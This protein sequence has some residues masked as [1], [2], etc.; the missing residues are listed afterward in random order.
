MRI[1]DLNDMIPGEG[2]PAP[3]DPGLHGLGTGNETAEALKR[4]GGAATSASLDAYQRMVEASRR[5]AML[6]AD[7]KLAEFDAN[8]EAPG[9][10]KDTHQLEKAGGVMAIATKEHEALTAQIA[11]QYDDPF[12]QQRIAEAGQQRRGALQR[13][14]AE[15]ELTQGKTA[16][17]QRTEANNKWAAL[18]ARNATNIQ[19]P[20]VGPDALRAYGRI[21]DNTMSLYELGTKGGVGY[22]RANE[23]A[24]EATTDAVIATYLQ[25]AHDPRANKPAL[26]SQMEELAKRQVVNEGDPRYKQVLNLLDAKATEDSA[27]LFA[28][29]RVPMAT[30]G[31]I[32][33]SQA[34]ENYQKMVDAERERLTK[35]HGVLTEEDGKYIAQIATIGAAQLEL[36]LRPLHANED[37]QVNT[38]HG[39]VSPMVAAGKLPGTLEEFRVLVPGY[40]NYSK[41]VQARIDNMYHT[42]KPGSQS[43]V[44]QTAKYVADDVMNY[45]V[46][47]RIDPNSMTFDAVV[48]EVAALKIAEATARGEANPQI[49]GQQFLA[50]VQTL[51]DSGKDAYAAVESVYYR[52]YPKYVQMR[53]DVDVKD[54]EISTAKF[55]AAEGLKL[56]PQEQATLAGAAFSLAM[57]Y[58]AEKGDL[59]ADKVLGFSST[60]LANK[61]QVLNGK[62]LG[63]YK[64]VSSVPE[65]TGAAAKAAVPNKKPLVTITYVDENGVRQPPVVVMPGMT[66]FPQTPEEVRNFQ[67]EH[68]IGSK[69]KFPTGPGT[70][71]S[72]EVN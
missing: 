60:V 72:F 27:T 4:L 49:R 20:I 64:V 38:A 43:S 57:K 2:A 58:K 71:V 36:R 46:S 21:R 11:G 33:A 16:L 24:L 66:G 9:G 19:A 17:V 14:M 8:L 42:L 45:L 47:K 5:S 67:L 54:A 10:L 56:N 35:E 6:D 59:P 3:Q 39:V 25:L 53:F 52:E 68:P 29:T 50:A 41:G 28:I 31:V 69:A 44:T 70:I 23:R 30:K 55:M 22:E 63:L 7:N 51:R 65:K 26:K 15:Y 61:E 13:H 34:Q 12:I 1:T 18:D 40:V 62:W 37:F 32:E 48:K